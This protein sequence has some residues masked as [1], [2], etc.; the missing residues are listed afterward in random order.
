MQ[1]GPHVGSPPCR[2][3]ACTRPPPTA[4]APV[5]IR[6]LCGGLRGAGKLT[7]AGAPKSH[8]MA[9]ETG[10]R[11]MQL[12]L[13]CSCIFINWTGLEPIKV[14]PV[15]KTHSVTSSLTAL[16]FVSLP[17]TALRGATFGAVARAVHH[18]RM[19]YSYDHDS[20]IQMATADHFPRALQVTFITVLDGLRNTVRF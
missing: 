19:W 6:K 4:L 8:P 11:S 5:A 12:R 10:S 9:C 13:F 17:R 15:K 3:L 14:A 1:C 20:T 7:C 18:F 16:R 2:V